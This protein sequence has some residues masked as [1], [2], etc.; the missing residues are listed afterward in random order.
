[1]VDFAGWRMPVQY[2]GVMA[3]HAAVRERAGLF[4]VSHMGE[5]RLRGSDALAN[6]Q[7]L[8]VNDAS[9]IEDGQAQYTAMVN[10]A[11]GIID[12][13][14]VYRIAADEYLLVVNAGTA[15]KDHEWIVSH[16]EGDV[17]VVNESADWAQ[18]AIQ[19]PAAQTVLDQLVE[20]DLSAIGYY[21]F[22][23]SEYGGRPAIISRTGYTGEDGFELYLAPALAA[24]FADEILEAGDSSGVIPTGLGARDTLRLEAGMMLYGNDMDEGR[25]PIEAKLGWIVKPDKGDFIGRD[26]LV[27]QRAEGTV[28]KIVAFKAVGRGIPRHGYALLDGDGSRVGEVTSGTFGPTLKEGIGMG[29]VTSALATPDNQIFIEMRGKSIEART[30]TS[31]F[32]RRQH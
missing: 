20:E 31:P 22:V 26:V 1:M 5:I 25:T 7:R 19:G 14:L 30:V 10:E 6:V 15:D 21:R 2:S 3:E 27:R 16:A 11:G 8:T 17:T 9:L 13:L 29:Y 32:Y 18:I 4:D 28:E 24:D 12:D 23:I